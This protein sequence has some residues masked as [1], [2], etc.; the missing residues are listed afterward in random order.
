M[1]VVK[2]IKRKLTCS[3]T[4]RITTHMKSQ[5][6]WGEPE[7]TSHS[8]HVYKQLQEKANNFYIR[9]VGLFC[10]YKQLWKK[11]SDLLIQSFTWQK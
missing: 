10:V 11:A 1:W 3:V 6:Y 5:I 4:V 2:F 8:R 9:L 7:Q